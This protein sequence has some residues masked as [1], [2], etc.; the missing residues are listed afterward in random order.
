MAKQNMRQI[1]IRKVYGATIRDILIKFSKEF[2]YLVLIAN[3]IAWPLAYYLMTFWLEKFPYKTSL[4]LWIF[5]VS[6]VISISI[7]LLTVMFNAYV[8]ANKNPAEVL[9]YE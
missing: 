6:G 4:S 8:T 1:S 7:S 5:I 9:R 2:L 3:V